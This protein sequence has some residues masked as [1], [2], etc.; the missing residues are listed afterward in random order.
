[1]N[2]SLYDKY[3]GFETFSIVVSNFYQKVLEDDK[4]AAYFEGVNM[5][6]LMTHQTNFIST[7]LGGP[8]KSK[9]IDLVK[10]HAQYKIT[11]PHFLQ[12]TTILEDALREAN[13]TSQDIKTI[14]QLISGFMDQIVAKH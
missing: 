9:N 14:I 13:V 1:M 12:V 2:E 8:N 4:L 3:G 11:L 5:T 10:A 7:A 6:Q